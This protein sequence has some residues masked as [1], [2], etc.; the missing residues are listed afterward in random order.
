MK[1]RTII[2]TG[3]L[4]TTLFLM[5]C[6]KSVCYECEM[7]ENGIIIQEWVECESAL[8]NTFTF[9]EKDVTYIFSN[10][11]TGQKTTCKKIN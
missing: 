6:Q 4:I 8:D 9:N 5:G 11:S 1:K 2:L 10:I 7:E 3:L